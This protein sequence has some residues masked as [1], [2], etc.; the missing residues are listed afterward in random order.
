MTTCVHIHVLVEMAN[1]LDLSNTNSD[2]SDADS[3][4]EETS[5][6]QAPSLLDRLKSPTASDL[7]RK[8]RV[9]VNQPPKGKKRCKGSTAAE[10]SVSPAERVRE[11]PD[12]QLSVVQGKLFC[13]ACRENVS[14]K[15][16]II[17]QHAK[18]SKHVAGKTRLAQKDKQERDIADMLV[19]YDKTTHPV[20][21]GLSES[22]RVYRVKVVRTFLRA[23]VP[24]QKVDQF[25]ELLE[26]NAFRLSGSS[27]LRELLPF[28]HE[29]EKHTIQREIKGKQVS[30]IFD[31]TTHVCEAMVIVLRFLDE[32][33]EIQQRVV[34]LMLLAKSLS[35]EEVARQLIVCLSTELGINSD[36]LVATMRDRASVNTVAIRTLGIVFPKIVDIGC[37]SHTLDH[38]GENL[39][40]P[41]LDEFIKVW[42]N[43]FS[44]SPKTKLAWKTKTGLTV[45]TYSA[46]RWWSKWEVMRHLH[47]AFGDV[48]S[49]VASDELPPSKSKLQDILDDPPKNRKL[50]MELAITIDAGEPFVK[51][52][53]RLEGDGPLVFSAYEEISTL[54]AVVANAH[55]PNANA[56]AAKLSSG[57]AVLK[58]QL[59]DYAEV[60]VKPAYEYFERKFDHDEGLQ[61]AV[62]LFKYARYFDP[63]KIGELK[64]SCN[65]IDNLRVFPMLDNDAALDALK[66]ELPRYMAIADGVSVLVK[67]TD[68]WKTHENE[69]PNWSTA[70]RMALLVQPSSAASERVFSILSNC[71]GDYQTHSLEDYI[72][73]SIMLQYNSRE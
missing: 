72:E 56:V 12:E 66:K 1:R 30:V 53:Y 48:S 7:S 40:T 47:D 24:L 34:R 21:E 44:R 35:G 25:R 3:E 11:F 55:H 65:D 28:I 52:T 54:R 14:V 41:I 8:R 39:N 6:E 4:A 26:E 60:C 5:G 59:I 33:W 23:G 2:S 64:P 10:P 51:A 43:M 27:H 73:T 61:R 67:K 36:L 15:K 42:I 68:W 62:S 38:V 70:C 29:Q 13:K 19:T 18:S 20:G 63:V 17:A 50:P 71:F 9:S 57:R 46:T 58:Q 45:P 37:F 31:G 16:S 69:L 22:V 49:F 32:K